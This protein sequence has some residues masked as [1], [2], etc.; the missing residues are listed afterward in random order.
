MMIQSVFTVIRGQRHYVAHVF[1]RFDDKLLAAVHEDPQTA[2]DFVN[3][4]NALEKISR[5]VNYDGKVYETAP[6]EIKP[7]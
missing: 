6:I 3:E 4:E 2:K 1:H 7:N 5:F